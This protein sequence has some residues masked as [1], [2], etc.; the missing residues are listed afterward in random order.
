VD[1]T[2]HTDIRRRFIEQ[3][4]RLLPYL[5]ALADENSRSG[6]PLMRPL[7]Y[8]HPDA[9]ESSC[10]APTTFMLGNGLLIAPPPD[11]ESPADYTV[12]LPAGDWYDYW[13]GAKVTTRP[14]RIAPALDRLPVFVRAGAIL[15]R[16]PLVQSTADT[17]QGPLS[18]D[19]YPGADC[20][21][22][23]YLDDGHSMAFRGHGYLRQ[24]LRCEQTADGLTVEFA[25]R[26]GTYPPWWRN[27]DVRVHD[28]QG[29]ARVA[30][31]GR[32]VASTTRRPGPGTLLV[33]ISDTAGPARL[34]IA[35]T[36]GS[37]AGTGGAVNR[38]DIG[39]RRVE[40]TAGPAP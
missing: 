14:V 24:L 9:L 4:Y 12:C 35:R 1:G 30:L 22:E 15:P 6:A 20:G 11:F 16:Q 40:S 31:D 38:A 33:S 13:S 7:F 34:T 26:E 2:R 36:D 19:I 37:G 23:I 27:I 10:E 28:W 3:R 8:D 25:A 17:P 29:A 21:G 5:Y 39:P 32:R 18:L